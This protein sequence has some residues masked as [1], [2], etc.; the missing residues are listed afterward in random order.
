[1]EE[2][3]GLFSPARRPICGRLELELDKGR[4]GRSQE[5]HKAVMDSTVA[6]LSS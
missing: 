2:L 3:L 4:G 6:Q 5:E 1:M